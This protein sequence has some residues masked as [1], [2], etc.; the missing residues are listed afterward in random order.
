MLS[1]A[2]HAPAIMTIPGLE[3]GRVTAR[4]PGAT[5]KGLQHQACF[6]EKHQASFSSEPLFLVA[7]K[8]RYATG[9]SPV[10]RA[11]GCA[12]P[13]SAGSSPAC[14]TGYLRSRRGIRRRTNVG[15]LRPPEHTSTGL[16]QNPVDADPPASTFSNLR[17]CASDK[18]AGRPGTGLGAKACLPSRSRASRQRQTDDTLDFTRRATSDTDFFCPSNSTARSRL[19]SSLLGC[20]MLSHSNSI[21]TPQQNAIT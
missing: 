18:R 7:A 8:S 5:A 2:D 6:V 17:R 16:W 10:R 20:A 14:A 4:S 11:R 12:R 3:H 19:D 9:R 13:V 15:S 1:A 21:P